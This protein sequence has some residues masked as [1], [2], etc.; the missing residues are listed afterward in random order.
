MT[1][2]NPIDQVA[3]ALRDGLARHVAVVAGAEPLHPRAVAA[4][5]GNVT[6]IA[7]DGG[8]DHA[9][10]AG[11]RPAALVGDLDSVS[12]DG[13]AWATEHAV[14]SRHDPDKDLTDTELALATAVDL[15]P[16]RLTLVAGGGDRLDHT[17]A[18]LGALGHPT[19][20]AVPIVEAWW[21]RQYLRVLHGP[22]RAR[23]T[24]LPDGTTVSLLSAH[25]TCDG[26]TATGV[27][28]AL[29]GARLGPLIGHGV[30]NET[31]AVEA[32][33]TVADGVLTIVVPDR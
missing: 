29:D 4:I 31:V 10:A 6:V 27:R 5:A 9:L 16:A 23:L 21:G 13:L 2:P 3:E 20:T 11:L 14:V 7:A 28:W 8:L 1:A 32:E 17:L 22:G 24:G 25:G 33:F 30:S 12:A 19:L 15:V 18:A 26:V